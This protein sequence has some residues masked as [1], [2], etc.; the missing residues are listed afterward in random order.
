MYIIWPQVERGRRIELNQPSFFQ[1]TPSPFWET[2]CSVSISKGGGGGG[3][4]GGGGG[5]AG[6]LEGVFTY[7][8]AKGEF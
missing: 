5:D 3:G 7:I 4:W 2:Y 1:F 8:A 6:E